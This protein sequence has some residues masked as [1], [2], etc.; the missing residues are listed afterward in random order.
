MYT[1][2]S[3][4]NYVHSEFRRAS[5]SALSGNAKKD[6]PE[7]HKAV[8]KNKDGKSCGRMMAQ[9]TK[10]GLSFKNNMSGMRYAGVCER[11][12]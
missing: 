6:A 3:L 2:F 12:L 10:R 9:A 4:A 1:F 8:L 11:L 7:G 5:T